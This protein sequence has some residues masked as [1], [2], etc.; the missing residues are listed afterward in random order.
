MRQFAIIGSYAHIPI[1]LPARHTIDSAGYDLAAAAT[2]E[3]VR[4]QVV[5]VPTGLK[6]YMPQ[7]EVLLLIIRSS[8]AVKK[9]CVLANQ[10]GVIDRDY[11]DNPENEGHIFIPIENRGSENVVIHAGD[12]IAQGLFV[13]FSITDNDAVSGQRTGGFGSTR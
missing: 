2:V 10:V 12:R 8:W 9:H 7:G 6:V 4:G 3:A 11:A 1:V 5:M 13:K